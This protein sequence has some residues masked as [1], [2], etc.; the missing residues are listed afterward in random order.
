MLSLTPAQ[1]A[2][3]TPQE[4]AEMTA[5][6]MVRLSTS[7]ISSILFFR[8][9]VREGSIYSPLHHSSVKVTERTSL[10]ILFRR[11]NANSSN[12]SMREEKFQ[13]RGALSLKEGSLGIFE[14]R[15]VDLNVGLVE[16]SRYYA[17]WLDHRKD[18]WRWDSRGAIIVF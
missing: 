18:H 10:V 9:Y 12:I 5:I 17:I 6:R 14:D 11:R 7:F 15:I 13:R 8:N 4:R 3:W 2:A 16:T 1:E